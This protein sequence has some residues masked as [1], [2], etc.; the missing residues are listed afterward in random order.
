MILVTEIGKSEINMPEIIKA[1]SISLD[2]PKSNFPAFDIALPPGVNPSG[3]AKKIVSG[4][5]AEPAFQKWYGDWAKKLHLNP[6]PDDP[7]HFYDYRAAFETGAMPNAEGHWPSQFKKEGHPRMIVNGINTITGQQIGAAKN[8]V[9][10]QGN[11]IP[12]GSIQL[13]QPEKPYKPSFTKEVIGG[14]FKE[15]GKGIAGVPRELAGLTETALRFG[16]GVTL[17]PA[18]VSSRL[19]G[20]VSRVAQGKS[21]ETAK[22]E[23]EKVA[24]VFQ[25]GEPWLPETKR[26][27]EYIG[28]YLQ[29]PKR[30]AQWSSEQI[31]KAF[32]IIKE[33]DK[34]AVPKSDWGKV[35]GYAINEG[36]DIASAI[37][38]LG[39][40][41]AI[42]RGVYRNLIKQQKPPSGKAQLRDLRKLE[43]QERLDVL[44][45]KQLLRDIAEVE[46]KKVAVSDIIAEWQ[47][48]IPPA[49]PPGQGFE[50]QEGRRIPRP[51]HEEPAIELKKPE[52][53]S[54]EF[55]QERLKVAL[56][57]PPF[58]RTAED[59]LIIQERLKQPSPLVVKAGSI[60]LD[61]APEI[62]APTEIKPLEIKVP[63]TVK[64]P[65]EMTLLEY[66]KSKLKPSV[67]E[68]ITDP[69]QVANFSG[70]HIKEIKAAIERGDVIPSNVLREYKGTEWADKAIIEQPKPKGGT[71][72]GSGLGG[73][74]SLWD[75]WEREGKIDDLVRYAK[76]KGQD[77]SEY[78]KEAGFNEETVKFL[79]GAIDKREAEKK[80]TSELIKELTETA[81]EAGKFPI[82]SI[83]EGMFGKIGDNL[84]RLKKV[85]PKEVSD[86][87]VAIDCWYSVPKHMADMYPQ[88]KIVL[89]V[90]NVRHERANFERGIH[91]EKV[92]PFIR[93]SNT[94]SKLSDKA[95]IR[96][97]ERGKALDDA[98]LSKMGINE[99]QRQA[100]Q[101]VREYLDWRW[102]DYFDTLIEGRVARYKDK[103]FYEDLRKGIKEKKLPEFP[104][105]ELY[106]AFNRLTEDIA[107]LREL[108]QTMGRIEAYFPRVRKRG[109]YAVI[110]EGENPIREHFQTETFANRRQKELQK[111]N[112]GQEVKVERIKRTPET[113]FQALNDY[114]LQWF[115]DQA[116]DNLKKGKEGVEES[117]LS[118]LQDEVLREISEDLKSR[119]WA[120]RGIKRREGPVV[121]GYKETNLKQVLLDD[122]NGYIGW[123]TKYL[124]AQDYAMALKHVGTENPGLFEYWSRFSKDM[125]RNTE[126]ADIVGA[127]ARAIAFFAYLG[128]NLKQIPLQI[129]QNYTMAIPELRKHTRFA[130]TNY[131]KAMINIASRKGITPEEGQ[132]LAYAEKVKWIDDPYARELT[133]KAEG[134]FKEIGKDVLR[135]I[136]WPLSGM[137]KY[138]RASALLAS[139]RIFRGKGIS[140][141]EA[142]IQAR[143]FTET[144]H[145]KYGKLN[146]PELM[147]GGD[148][149]APVARIAYTFL[150]WP[151]QYMLWMKNNLSEGNFKTAME[152]LAWISVFGGTLSLPFLDDILDIAEKMTGRPLRRDVIAKMK[153]KVGEK[154]TKGIMYGLPGLIGPGFSISGSMAI[155]IPF[156][157][158]VT[159][160]EDPL[161]NIFSVYTGMG[162]KVER[163]AELL[164]KGEYGLAAQQIPMIA[165]G[166]I[167]KGVQGYRK[168]VTTWKG[169]PIFDYT[170]ESPEP[171]KYTLGEA[172]GKAIGFMPARQGLAWKT[173]ESYQNMKKY[174]SE[175]AD[176][177]GSQYARAYVEEDDKAQDEIMDKV[178]KINDWLAD[179]GMEE[180]KIQLKPIVRGFL[181][182]GKKMYKFEE[183]LRE[184]QP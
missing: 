170:Q 34:K 121:K 45:E 114:D 64:Q 145:H 38:A 51:P 77:V 103:P 181:R 42:G 122:M 176:E 54:V 141:A 94:K 154:G 112:P 18:D 26:N 33:L 153:S 143:D 23:S 134:A 16:A 107:P 80:P 132:F 88:S 175:L 44:R 171:F 72:L 180:F 138:N 57:T 89:E 53:P 8:I 117:I 6:N 78:L 56:D 177:W 137:E 37:I 40:A 59:R 131:Q 69:K 2:A 118:K 151:H 127:K 173:T 167:A 125:M 63:E 110:M 149:A 150:T 133:G 163:G 79:A 119:G 184:Q 96:A 46:A 74:Q 90:E 41:G 148:I 14:T 65:W 5:F 20:L 7:R 106:D 164:S 98:E 60:E 124:A 172:I 95:I 35:L 139:Y 61:I 102:G 168:G 10:N 75:K 19:T 92:E 155:G 11:I 39:G 101:S 140:P 4:S 25:L 183:P 62:K 52:R 24:K 161:D 144:A 85:A 49:L 109:Q 47:K 162:R 104:D 158:I 146:L 67:A 156:Y 68:Q 159:G 142:A 136:S 113:V 13:D 81:V 9:S 1:G 36:T 31:K 82:P 99:A 91:L 15:L 174:Y 84:E 120:Q 29:L 76:K 55:T 17:L 48:P 86:L 28:Q 21:F 182:P 111:Q 116:V 58:L 87:K 165:V 130:A 27:L 22:K 97:D 83:E 129:T 3:A 73:F 30:F 152:S 123:K 12:A 100:I 108:R 157:D 128:A 66:G 115:I 70:Q 50:L 32:P 178:Q 147:R 169:K 160:R 179:K 43:E 93:L 105:E 166:S 135:I 126:L 71:Y